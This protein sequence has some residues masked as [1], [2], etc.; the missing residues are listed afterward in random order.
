MVDV[1]VAVLTPREM[2]WFVVEFWV[3]AVRELS[4]T[5]RLVIACHLSPL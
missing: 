4:L 5:G 1:I 3:W 2:S